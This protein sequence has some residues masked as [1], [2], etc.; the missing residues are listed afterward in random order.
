MSLRHHLNVGTSG[1][2]D[3]GTGTAT[4][5]PYVEVELISRAL[6]VKPELAIKQPVR[7]G[8]RR[9]RGKGKYHRD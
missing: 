1:H 4:D 7:Y 6:P 2:I 3:Y 9:K 8:P 5:P